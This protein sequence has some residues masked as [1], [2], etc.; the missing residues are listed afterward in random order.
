M[1]DNNVCYVCGEKESKEKQG[2][3][4]KGERRERGERGKKTII[5]F[6]FSFYSS[7]FSRPLLSFVFSAFSFSFKRERRERRREEK[8][9]RRERERE[10]NRR[11]NERKRERKGKREKLIAIFSSRPPLFF[12]FL[13]L[14]FFTLF[15]F[16]ERIGASSHVASGAPRRLLP[17][18]FKRSDH[19]SRQGRRLGRVKIHFAL[20]RGSR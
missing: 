10:K 12:S 3:R 13:S 2:E 16:T 6:F 4:A 7:F 5:S 20:L 9:E 19:Y 18:F 1:W 11:E 14:F 15:S 8:E 17:G